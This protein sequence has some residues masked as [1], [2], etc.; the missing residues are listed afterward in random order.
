[1]MAFVLYPYFS[2]SLGLSL[3]S[4]VSSFSLGSF[5]FLWGSPYWA[6]RA[7]RSG[8]KL[9]LAIGI[10][11]L[12][13][14][15]IV[16]LFLVL[17][18][19][20]LSSSLVAFSL[21]T[22]RLLYGVTA[23]AIVPVAQAVLAEKSGETGRLKA[24]TRHSMSLHAGRLIGPLLVWGGLQL[25]T[26]APLWISVILLLVI[27]FSAL[28]MPR[29]EPMESCV[30]TV[31]VWDF[32]YIERHIRLLSLAFMVT[33]LVGI[34]QSSLTDHVQKHLSL[35]AHESAQL[36]LKFLLLSSLVTLAIQGFMQGFLKS[37]WQGT[38]P[39]GAFA[40]ALACCLL[41]SVRSEGGLWLA[42]PIFAAGLA[43]LTPS[44]TAALSL[45]GR[46]GE[47]TKA[48]GALAAMHTLG[49][50]LGG[51]CSGSLMAMEWSPLYAAA[52]FS[53]L[54]IAVAFMVKDRPEHFLQNLKQDPT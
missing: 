11:G 48:A 12:L 24:M 37:P 6:R 17:N 3:G 47:Q 26:S 23:S 2:E 25:G 49:Y 9:V 4:I 22:S 34:L 46:Q 36:T 16:L 1:M 35:D 40:L 42:L 14:S 7:E 27:F 15:Q 13:L 30:S 53:L 44:Y 29:R 51:L 18:A 10:S 52:L 19:G 28:L 50:A 38:M 43:L 45:K 31:S 33:L 54:L 32:A 20:H 41:M 5:L 8:H 39:V 21:W